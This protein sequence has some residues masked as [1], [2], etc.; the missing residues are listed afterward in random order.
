MMTFRPEALTSS[1]VCVSLLLD[2]KDSKNKDPA[3]A[4]SSSASSSSSPRIY[5]RM[6]SSSI[7]GIA[8]C[9]QGVVEQQVTSSRAV[10]I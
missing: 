4:S 8:L 3:A 6:K 5:G 10:Y 9:W 1:R 2:G 7:A